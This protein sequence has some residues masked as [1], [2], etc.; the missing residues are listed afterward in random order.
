[1]RNGVLLVLL[2]VTSLSI[3]A[4]ETQ[5]D[6]PAKWD[7]ER[8]V[9]SIGVVLDTSST[10]DN[11]PIK[12][13][14]EVSRTLG[15]IANDP[16]VPITCSFRHFDTAADRGRVR[17]TVFVDGESVHSQR[18]VIGA[19]TPHAAQSSTADLDLTD[20]GPDTV[21]TCRAKVQSP[22]RV[23]Q[24]T[25]AILGLSAPGSANAAASRLPSNRA[26][27][28][29][30]PGGLQ[31]Q[32]RV[33]AG[34]IVRAPRARNA[35]VMIARAATKST[36]VKGKWMAYQTLGEL[37]GG[38]YAQLICSISFSGAATVKGK[39]VGI[40]KIDGKRVFR[41]VVPLGGPALFLSSQSDL[42][43]YGPESVMECA[44]TTKGKTQLAAGSS[45]TVQASVSARVVE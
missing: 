30:Q 16:M 32:E 24:G 41:K 40:I 1:M 39:A 2:T 4:S 8:L 22:T 19:D 20:F 35:A 36:S 3:A 21:I 38:A 15:D 12:G 13:V 37:A 33:P 34:W 7:I 10:G 44:V 14:W 28:A 11:A 45:A 5:F 43:A 29:T 18:V 17:F 23:G 27:T 31:P 26:D 9:S 42:S 25:S 6:A